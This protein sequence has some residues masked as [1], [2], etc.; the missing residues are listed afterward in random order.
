MLTLIN[1]P[2][3]YIKAFVCVCV[4][5]ITEISSALCVDLYFLI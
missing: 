2:T 5:A 3:Y 1:N 4:C